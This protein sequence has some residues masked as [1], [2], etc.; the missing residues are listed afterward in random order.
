[1]SLT[2]S[3]NL[4]DRLRSLDDRAA[5][6]RFVRLYVPLLCFWVR[7]AGLQEADTAD[8]VQ[9]VLVLL[10]RK[11]PEFSY[12]RSKSFR[13]WLRALS[14][15]KVRELHRRRTPAQAHDSEEIR[16]L[17]DPNDGAEAEEAEYRAYLLRRATDLLRHEFP[18][19]TWAAFQQ[20]VLAGRPA[21]EVA[22]ELGLQVGTVYSAKSRVLTR[23]RQELS[24]LLD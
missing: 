8:V 6:D 7:R 13:N 3:V 14:L 22:A 9:E 1:M 21:E 23:L 5:W 19:S 12:D 10:T 2:T 17:P 24:G 11:L 20:Y 15:N 4:L 18:P 16:E